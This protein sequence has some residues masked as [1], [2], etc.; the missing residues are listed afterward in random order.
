MIA[1]KLTKPEMQ[2]CGFCDPNS[3][4]T[5][6]YVLGKWIRPHKNFGPL[7]V[8]KE[9]GDLIKFRLEYASDM[10]ETRVFVCEIKKSKAKELW[11]YD[12]GFMEEKHK[13][14][15]LNC[16]SGTIFASA[17]KLIKEIK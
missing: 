5:T 10:G 4:A 13:Y 8:F 14:I 1:F 9:W 3:P 11:Y 16:P 17:V 12:T 2:S 6:K 15:G 7:A